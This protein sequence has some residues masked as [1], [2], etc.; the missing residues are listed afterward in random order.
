MPDSGIARAMSLLNELPEIAA[1]KAFR[2]R[3]SLSLLLYVCSWKCMLITMAGGGGGGE[4]WT[5][6]SKHRLSYFYILQ[7]GSFVDAKI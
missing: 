5:T 6:E 1:E 4:Y 2:V 3:C 7:V